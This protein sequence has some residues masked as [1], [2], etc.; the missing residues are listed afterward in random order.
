MSSRMQLVPVNP[1]LAPL[2]DIAGM[3]VIGRHPACSARLSHRSISRRHCVIGPDSGQGGVA[4]IHDLGSKNGTRLNG[5][6]IRTA[7]LS[8][9]DQLSIGKLK[10][11]VVGGAEEGGPAEG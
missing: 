2:I 5:H 9:G 8:P 10:F 6:R 3:I 1:R 4:L 7:R 11:I